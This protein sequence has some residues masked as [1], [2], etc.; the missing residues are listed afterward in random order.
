MKGLQD[1][2]FMDPEAQ[3]KFQE[4]LEMLRKAMLDTFFKELHRRICDDVA[5]ADGAPEG[6]GERPEPDAL[7]ED[8]RRTSRTS[9]QFM[10]KHGDL[11]GPNPPQSL[12]ELI[13]QM[14]Q[15]IGQMQS[16]AR[17]PARRTCASSSKTCWRRR[18]LTRSCWRS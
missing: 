13:A 9:T 10:A 4:L 11:F 7:G 3:H 8:G 17:Q 15:Q 16:H 6:D 12:E 14:Q 5:G 2:E 18:S 1:Y